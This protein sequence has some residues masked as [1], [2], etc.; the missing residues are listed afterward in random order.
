VQCIKN[1]LT[2][3]FVQR[4]EQSSQNTDEHSLNQATS[5]SRVTLT[6]FK[7]YSG[8]A[9]LLGMRAKPLAFSMCN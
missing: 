7:S 2:Y 9:V 8:K 3:N 4:R 5:T 1:D 6:T